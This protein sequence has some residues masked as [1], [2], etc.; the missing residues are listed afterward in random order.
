MKIKNPLIFAFSI[1]FFIHPLIA[2]NNLGMAFPL[3]QNEKQVVITQPVLINPDCLIPAGSTLRVIYVPPKAG[4]RGQYKKKFTLEDSGALARKSHDKALKD[5]SDKRS[6]EEKEADARAQNTIWQEEIAFRAALEQL[7]LDDARFVFQNPGSPEI[8][9]QPIELIEGMLL[10]EKENRVVVLYVQE[11]SAAAKSGIVS[12][13]ILLKLND[14]DFLGKLSNF[15]KIYSE[16]KK[17]PPSSKPHLD[18]LFLPPKATQP[19]HA[20]L[21]LPRSLNSDFWSDFDKKN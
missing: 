3:K 19:T 1:L 6:P 2:A 9:I 17:N 14:K 13:S 11:N 5:F 21:L 16:E 12:E 8:Q 4:E 15:Q 20:T 10:T 7:T 18:L